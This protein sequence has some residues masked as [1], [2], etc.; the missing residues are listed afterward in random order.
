MRGKTKTERREATAV[1]ARRVSECFSVSAIV[2][3]KSIRQNKSSPSTTGIPVKTNK[4][5]RRPEDKK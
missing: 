4:M 1:I 2:A 5:R 3:R